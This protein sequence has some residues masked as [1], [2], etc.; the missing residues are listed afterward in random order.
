[1]LATPNPMI[2]PPSSS[3][4]QA[5][6]PKPTMNSPAPTTTTAMSMDAAVTGTL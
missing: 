3:V 1:M 5:E 4:H 6:L 2:T